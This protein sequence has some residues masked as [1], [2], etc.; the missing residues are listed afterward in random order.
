MVRI[1]YFTHAT[2]TDNERGIATGWQPGELSAR[3][4]EQALALSEQVRTSSFDTVYS[5]DQQ[6]A[7]ESAALFFP[8]RE[9]QQDP[10]LCE[11]NYGDFT[12][13]PASE[14]MSRLVEYIET[15]FPNGECYRD[16]ERRVSAFLDDV[17]QRH[18]GAS[19][20]VVAHQAP[21]LAFEVLL[22]GKSWQEAIEQDWRISGAWQP[23]WVYEAD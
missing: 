16:V 17:R 10:R 22:A 13:L 18:E 4:R 9:V 20:A 8:G 19:I 1:T 7:F 6:R 12:G 23:G 21:Q 5:S 2:T 14:F 3:G 11:C 15:P